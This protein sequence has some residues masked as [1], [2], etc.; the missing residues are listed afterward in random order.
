MDKSELKHQN[1]EELKFFNDGHIQFSPILLQYLGAP[2]FLCD[3]F[4][5]SAPLTAQINT[6][7]IQNK[8]YPVFRTSFFSRKKNFFSNRPNFERFKINELI[9][10][11][12]DIT[13]KIKIFFSDKVVEFCFIKR[14]MTHR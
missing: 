2:L 13:Q 1:Q 14:R 6:I 10:H 3:L 11:R 8:N 12:S 5:F 9:Q 7:L 4:Y